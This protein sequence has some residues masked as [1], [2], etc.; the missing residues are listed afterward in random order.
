M[1][2]GIQWQSFFGT[3]GQFRINTA[4]RGVVTANYIQTRIRAAKDGQWDSILTQYMRPW[5][6]VF[7]VEGMDFDELLQRDLD[8]ARVANDL[9]PYLMGTETSRVP[10]LSADSRGACP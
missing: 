8:D 3:S 2:F 6:E 10:S 4:K 9:I 7:A 1:S 5:R